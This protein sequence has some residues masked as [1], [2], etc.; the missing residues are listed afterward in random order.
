MPVFILSTK[1][2]SLFR[3]RQKLLFKIKQS[4]CLQLMPGKGINTEKMKEK[5]LKILKETTRKGN[6]EVELRKEVREAIILLNRFEVNK[7]R[8][9]G[10]EGAIN[11]MKKIQRNIQSVFI[12]FKYR[13]QRDMFYKIFPSSKYQSWYKFYGN[14]KIGKNRVYVIEP[15]SPINIR[16]ENL[17]RSA[18]DKFLRRFFSW[19]IFASFFFIRSFYI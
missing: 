18:C 12:T 11:K 6:D 13:L 16:W 7:K 9:T 19:V 4:L 15:P 8:I 1:L 3:E 14:Y 10:T 5:L 2:D 17:D